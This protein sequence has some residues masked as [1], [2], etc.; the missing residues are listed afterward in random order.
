M[1]F[2]WGRKKEETKEDSTASASGEEERTFGSTARFGIDRPDAAFAD[3]N[4]RE[5]SSMPDFLSSPTSSAADLYSSAPKFSSGLAADDNEEDAL[6]ALSGPLFDPKS[7]YG[8]LGRTNSVTGRS[9]DY[10]FAEDFDEVRKKGWGEQM[11]YLTGASYLTGATVG[12]TWGLVEGLRGSVGKTR[13]LRANAV[14]N[15]MGKRGALIGQSMGV[16]ALVFSG[17]ESIMYHY[18]RDDTA[19]N[20][21]AA[22]AGA[23]LLFKSTKGLRAAGQWGVGIACVTT[24][25]VYASRQGYYGRSVRGIL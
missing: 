24:G 7:A 22:G 14:L 11:V 16:L 25:L 4:D 3:D 10:V 8:S 21:V 15:S 23:G 1:S 6:P 19:L 18:T 2:L 9:L 17:M 13:R 5:V 12:C 20:Y